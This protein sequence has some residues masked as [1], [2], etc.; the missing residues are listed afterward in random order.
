MTILNTLKGNNNM[1]WFRH[2]PP[3]Y[4]PHKEPVK[5]PIPQNNKPTK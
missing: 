2:R 3:K 1:S 4:P 5:D